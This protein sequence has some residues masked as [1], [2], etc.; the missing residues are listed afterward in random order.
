VTNKAAAFYAKL[1]KKQLEMF[2]ESL[3]EDSLDECKET[4][5]FAYEVAKKA[6]D[7]D[8]GVTR[9]E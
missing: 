5:F 3:D 4:R 7:D 9:K 2:I 6:Y 1:A 8:L